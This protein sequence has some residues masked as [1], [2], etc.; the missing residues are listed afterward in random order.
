MVEKDRLR[1]SMG[2]GCIVEHTDIGREF[3]WGDVGL[4]SVVPPLFISILIFYSLNFNIITSFLPSHSSLKIIP[5]VS[6]LSN[7]CPFYL[8][9]IYIHTNYPVHI[10]LFVCVFSGLTI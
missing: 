5:Y 1:G 2:E 10:M 7:L 6:H 9:V 8:S 3:S 4:Q